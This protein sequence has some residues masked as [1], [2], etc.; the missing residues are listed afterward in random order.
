MSAIEK[1][2]A[3]ARGA[4]I[5]PEWTNTRKARVM[6]SADERAKLDLLTARGYSF[7][8]ESWTD[9]PTEAVIL[10]Q[11]SVVTGWQRLDVA[12]EAEIARA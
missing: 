2:L 11:R 8:F 1:L 5:E 10:V 9:D 6:I 12:Y 7:K 4:T 3:R